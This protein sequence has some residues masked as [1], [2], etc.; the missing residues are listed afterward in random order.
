[1]T[2]FSIEQIQEIHEKLQ[3]FGQK[4]SQLS[5]LNELDGSEQVPILKNGKNV[6]TSILNIGGE[7][8]SIYIDKPLV[9]PTI[10]GTWIIDGKSYSQ[11]E[12]IAQVGTDVQ[13]IGS[14]KW[15]ED[16]NFS[17]P[18]EIGDDSDFM[19]ISLPLSNKDSSVINIHNI[20]RDREIKASLKA[21]IKGLFIN[22]TGKLVKAEGF[23]TSY[24]SV[25]VTFKYKIYY[26][27]VTEGFTNDSIIKLPY[28]LKSSNEYI[29]LPSITSSLNEYFIVAIP[30]A[31]GEVIS[32]LQNN[33]IDILEAFNIQERTLIESTITPYYIFISRNKGAFNNKNININFK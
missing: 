26:G 18:T 31:M 19:N 11:K 17:S 21:P 33:G 4:D 15:I 9:S 20:N 23:M 16:I 25:K 1:M 14:F 32:I 30:K 12:V 28:T 2:Y 13:W 22:D 24:D 5:I 29:S 7:G 10:Q 27:N 3:E 6:L 8:G